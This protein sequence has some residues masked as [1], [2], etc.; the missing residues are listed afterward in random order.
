L[1]WF[2]P[3]GRKFEINIQLGVQ[4]SGE[5]ATVSLLTVDREGSVEALRTAG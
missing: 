2:R 1:G 3:G 4:T 5:V